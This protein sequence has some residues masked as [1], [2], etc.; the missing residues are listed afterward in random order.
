[1][2]GD[3]FFW[4]G[5]LGLV[6]AVSTREQPHFHRYTQIADSSVQKQCDSAKDTS[7][8][9]EGDSMYFLLLLTIE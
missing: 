8:E 1:M 6:A 3:F 2:V 4:R 9:V 7:K 5:Q